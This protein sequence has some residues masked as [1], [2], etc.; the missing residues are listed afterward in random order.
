MSPRAL[1]GAALMALIALAPPPAGGL[2][3][4]PPSADDVASVRFRLLHEALAQAERPSADWDPGQRD[5]AGFVRLLFRK[6]TLSREALW[7]RKDGAKSSFLTA[8][9]LLAYN[10]TPLARAVDRDRAET[11]DLLAFYDPEKPPQD[12]WHLVVVL[13]PPGT[14]PDRLLAVYHNGA[15]PPDGAVRKVWVDDLVAGPA[16]WRPIPE[17]PRFLG[18]FRWN[19]FGGASE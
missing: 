11:G 12:A 9:E 6:S 1:S 7:T 15:A 14:A 3:A 13:R 10:F 2:A 17:N 8:D 18:A 16:A 5:C 4:A 19:G